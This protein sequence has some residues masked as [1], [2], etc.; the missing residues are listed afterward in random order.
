MADSPE[1]APA[2]LFDF[3]PPE[4]RE[5]GGVTSRLLLAYVE[6]EGGRAA[7]DDLLRRTGL[8]D[9]EPDL[10][11]E[12]YWFSFET[13]IRLLEAAAEVLEDPQVGVHVGASG[14]DFNV[15]QGFKLSLRALGSPQL[16]YKAIVRASGKFTLTHRMEAVDVGRD[17][18]KLRYVGLTGK[19]FHPFDCQLN[20]GYLRAVP[21]IFGRPAARVK[22]PIC[23]RDGGDV[24]VYEVRWESDYFSPRPLLGAAGATAAALSCSALLAPALVPVAAASGAALGA[25]IAVGQLRRRRRRWQLLEAKVQQQADVADRLATSLHDLVSDLRLDEVLE[26]ITI[27]AQSA[28]GGKEFALLI[29][30]DGMRCQ[31]SSGL[32][33][34]SLARLER[35]AEH[36]DALLEEP[37][38]LDDL[39]EVPHLADLPL[40]ER[41]PLRSLCAAPLVYHGRPLG[42]LVALGSSIESFLPHDVE[43][44]QSYAAQAAIALTN[45]RLYELQEARASRDPLTG[46]LNHRESHETVSRA[47]ARCRRHGGEFSV[48]LFDLDGFKLVNDS[49]GHAEG[50]R[51]LSRAAEVLATAGR[52]TDGAFRVGGDE[53]AL[54]LPSTSVPAATG[55]AERARRRIAELDGRVSASYG[56]AAWPDDGPSKDTLLARADARLYEMKRGSGALGQ[57]GTRHLRDAGERLARHGE[58]HGQL[59]SASRLSAK[60]APLV[61]PDEIARATVD[62][63]HQAFH[64][65]L[66]VIHRLDPDGMLRPVAGAGPLTGQMSSFE[67]WAQPLDRGTNGRVARSGE[68]AIVSDTSRD[69]DF[70]PTDAPT[71]AGSELVVPIR[72]AGKVWGVLNLG[73]VEQD[74]FDTDDLL[75]AD[76]V[77]AQVGAALH[78]SHLFAEL[79]GAFTT[80]LAV[81]GDALE[82]KDAYT[83][84]H[85]RDVAELTE[86]VGERLALPDGEIRNVRYAA[87]LHDI[88]KISVPSEILA[89]RG[90]LEDHEFDL[91]KRHTLTGAAM[92][93]RIPFFESVH[94]LVR[95]AHERWDGHG[96]PDGLAGEEIPLGARIICACDAFH[97]MTSTRPY[98]PAM[99]LHEALAELERNA[100]TQFDPAVVDALLRALEDE[101]A[102]TPDAADAAA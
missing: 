34:A 16:A 9:R 85:A 98:R 89:K 10:R 2:P 77:A 62:E 70:L 36:T 101:A 15:G 100:G 92:L 72:V 47:L 7:V 88:G 44:L 29:E 94:P 51:V 91:M 4:A 59:A 18:A 99:P 25:G 11:D 5:T 14:L 61:E 66:A 102:E 28:V 31:S 22:H 80:T 37:L 43:V 63:L 50:D 71:N 65:L 96:Y 54:L 73:Q 39:A 78:R 86:R 64:Y 21:E 93:E 57:R 46:L 19:G 1:T 87:L 24:C 32:P 81:L 26:K 27:N 90:P 79:E 23:A 52:E 55:A 84:A 95:S 82:S 8:V 45:A 20:I 42:V 6:R 76:M 35:W 68:P 30:D 74:A 38:T 41:M 13:K 49:A 48:A 40:D 56:I 17:H 69:P 33:T 58:R 12:N 60:L 3:P 75:F 67:D 97:A 83:A 53:F